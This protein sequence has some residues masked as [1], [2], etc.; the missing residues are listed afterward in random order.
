MKEIQKSVTN[1]RRGSLSERLCR[2]LIL[3]LSLYSLVSLNATIL[4]AGVATLSWN[5]PTTNVDGTVLTDLAGYKIRYGTASGNYS[6][7]IDVGNVTTYTVPSLVDG[8]TYYFA[9]TAYDTSGNESGY[10]NEVSKT[11]SSGADTTPPAGTITISNGAIYT[12]SAPVTLNVSATDTSGVS[13]MCI[14]NTNVCTTWEA[15]AT[16]KSWSLSSGGGIKTVYIWFRDSVG[17]TNSTSYSDSITLD[18]TAPTGSV[19]INSGAAST[20]ST[21]VTVTM[22][23]TD[24]N[25]VAQMQLSNDNVTWS[26]AEAYSA[27]KAWTLTSGDGTKTVYVKFRDNAGN[28]SQVYSDTISL[29]TGTPITTASPAGG[30]Y[31]SAQTVTLTANKAATIYFTTNGA[32][33]TTSSPVYTSP[34]SISATKTLKFFALDTAGNSGS[35]K[36]EIYTI[37]TAMPAFSSTSPASGSFIKTAAVGYT[38]S[39]N[40]NSGKITFVRTG[41]TLDSTTHVYNFTNADKTIGTHNVNTA[42]SL[43]NGAVYTL[44]FDA[45]D[46]AGNT[47]T[48]VSNTGIIYD[49]TGASVSINSP[50]SNSIVNNTSV[51]YALSENIS[52]GAIVYTRTGGSPDSLSP[53]K[54]L[55]LNGDRTAGSHTVNTGTTL[56]EGAVY[57]VGFEN[58][59]D[60][61]GN[62]TANIANINVTFESGA[63][64]ISNTSPASGAIITT[65]DINYTLSEAASSGK[66]TFT[67]TGGSYDANSPHIYNL[68]SAELYPGTHAVTS[69]LLLVDGA[70]YTVSFDATDMAGNPATTVSNAM[71]FYDSNYVKIPIGNVD[72]TGK[73]WNR[74]DGA[75]LIKLSTCFG[76]KAGDKNWNPV[77]DINKNGS[78]NNKIDGNDLMT[79]GSHFGEVAP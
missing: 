50:A 73:S 55:L 45:T 78:S 12:T 4:T 71:V 7:T 5:P 57:S 40:V 29:S 32:V 15:Y 66:V 6:Q 64:V 43:T 75:D 28:W 59:T 48:T 54:Y 18:T 65:A 20:S 72:S 19:T 27:S 47:A 56:V 37:D 26:A 36:T 70:F 2:I 24:T 77:C 14:S 31:K 23:A 61:A 52:T 35:V 38:L 63:L 22:S 58:V 1:R 10:S 76:S 67:W 39:E 13:Q 33:P 46:L 60:A 51:T 16:S 68:F 25:G 30:T 74:V 44:S 34:I 41:G 9:V 8:S 49:T 11:L 3:T 21:S 79:F 17:N 69:N 62:M 42:M 53:H